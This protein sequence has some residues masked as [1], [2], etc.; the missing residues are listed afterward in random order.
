MVKVA[1]NDVLGRYMYVQY[2][3]KYM[4]TVFEAYVLKRRFDLER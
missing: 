1:Q 2:M 4:H 3:G